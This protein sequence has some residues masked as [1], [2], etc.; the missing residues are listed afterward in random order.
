MKFSN[1]LSEMAYKSADAESK[2]SDDIGPFID[3]IIVFSR[4]KPGVL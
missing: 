1:Y 3:Y 2:M 4:R